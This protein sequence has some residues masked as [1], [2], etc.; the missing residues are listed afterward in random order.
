MATA[1]VWILKASEKRGWHWRRFFGSGEGDQWGGKEWIKSLASVR[2]LREGVR[3]GNTILAWQ[4]G[5]GIVGLCKTARGGYE[6]NKGSGKYDMVDL[7]ASPCLEWTSTPI[8]IGEMKQSPVLGRMEAL[9]MPRG[10]VF[11]VTPREWAEIRKLIKD[12]KLAT[13][14][15]LRR[16]A[17]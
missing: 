6:E 5:D 9:R 2:H 3:K 16:F 10:T 13:P 15:Q 4:V 17:P 12:N 8:S 1:R 11:A 7:A 14:A